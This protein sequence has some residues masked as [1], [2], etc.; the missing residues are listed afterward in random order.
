MNE[1]MQ[2]QLNRIEQKVQAAYDSAEKTRKYFL[3][4]MI[5]SIVVVI[6]PLVGIALILPVF[7]NALS[8]GGDINNTLDALGL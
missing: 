3:W 7:L 8:G 4:T 1:D 6:L 2:E 5:G